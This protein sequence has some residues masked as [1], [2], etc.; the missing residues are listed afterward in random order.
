[1]VE[2]TAIAV[3][4]EYQGSD[5]DERAGGVETQSAAARLRRQAAVPLTRQQ[6]DPRMLRSDRW[7]CGLLVL[8]TRLV[9]NLDWQL[10]FHKL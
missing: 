1:M 5:D 7:F 8:P 2:V 3:V 6:R 4:T 10:Q 9:L